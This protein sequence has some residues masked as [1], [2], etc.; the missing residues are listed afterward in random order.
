[1][2][3]YTLRRSHRL[4]LRVYLAVLASL[5]LCALLIGA[6]WHVFYNEPRTFEIALTS[7]DGKP[8]GAAEIKPLPRTHPG[9]PSFNV[10]MPD[11]ASFVATAQIG[12]PRPPLRGLGTIALIALAVGVGAYP[13]IRRLTRRLERL[14]TSV[15]ALGAG[16]LA[17]RVSVEGHDEVARLAMSFN[18]A[19]ARIEALLGA[20]RTLLANA[21]HE[22]R[23]P[24][25]RVR[26]AVELL[27]RDGGSASA[28]AEIARNIAELDQLIDEILLASRLEATDAAREPIENIDLTA[29]VAEECARAAA[30]FN[31]PV[32]SMS[33]SEKLLRRLVRNLLDNAR[34]YA[35]LAPADVTLDALPNEMLRLDVCDR[36]PGVPETERQ[37]IFEPFYRLPGASE[38]DGSVG[39]G[40]ALVRQIAR[41][42][43][44]DVVCL[45]REGGGTCFRVTLHR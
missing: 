18:R 41:R 13:V 5:A 7:P 23:S 25:A 30:S 21:S 42:H 40:L 32:I 3:E 44:G 43:G 27:E 14:Q 8:A 20:Q 39:L 11:G 45:P 2:A 17:A 4:Y 31:G 16:Y 15:D 33:G 10:R 1:M 26:M 12:P 38:R 35:P 24:L 34:R 9:P 22:L 28:R 19:A 29:L 36:G 37:K 6:A